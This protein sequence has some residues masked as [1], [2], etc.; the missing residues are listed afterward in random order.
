M[1]ETLQLDAN[2]TNPSIHF[3]GIDFSCLERNQLFS[4]TDNT[5]FIVT[6]NA[7]Y[8]VRAQSDPDFLNIINSSHC[9]FDGQ[10]PYAFARLLY[11]NYRIEKISGSDLIYDVC[12]YAKQH[13]HSLFLLGG[14]PEVNPRAVAK[15]QETYGIR[16]DGFSPPYQPY[17][18]TPEHNEAILERIKQFRPDYLFVAFGTIK[19]ERWIV[20]NFAFLQQHGVRMVVGCGGTFDFVSG[21][22]QRAPRWVQHAGLEGIWRLLKEPR[23]YR[24]KRLLLSARF[25]AVFYK[26]HI[27][28][29]WQRPRLS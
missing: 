12:K 19:Q 20:D 13:Q 23:W 3:C 1:K 5:Q 6:A 11:P 18:F 17:P 27:A 9:T 14:A 8:I 25:F 15:I 2:P 22:I 16:V 7:E 24:L 26:H 29:A 28:S 4:G 10:I 21:H